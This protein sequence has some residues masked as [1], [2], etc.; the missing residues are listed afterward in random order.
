MKRHVVLAVLALCAVA[1]AQSYDEIWTSNADVWADSITVI[2]IQNTD[3][4]PAPEL[5]WYGADLGRD[6]DVYLW[7]LDCATGEVADV[8]SDN[9]AI[10][11]AP[12]REPRLLDVN[13]DGRAEILMLVQDRGYETVHWV[14]YGWMSGSGTGS[15]AYRPLNRPNL[16]QNQPNPVTRKTQIRYS[17]P[18]SASVKLS[19]YDASGRLVKSLAEGP[20]EAGL[21][22]AEWLRDDADGKPLPQG[23]Y[24]YTLEADGKMISRK[25]LVV[26]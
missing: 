3:D 9:Y 2:G 4:D 17:L 22:S 7:V 16:E 15:G 18:K 14:L 1:T 10:I 5:V 13:A 23:S 11:A 12:G 21:H 8:W 20:A 24:Y 25:A 6:D 26:E 19:V